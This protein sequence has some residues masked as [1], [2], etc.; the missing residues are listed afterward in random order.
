[1]HRSSKNP[2]RAIALVIVLAFLVLISVMV[3]A[4]LSSVSTEL[5]SSK[6]FASGTNARQLA[7]SAVQAVMGQIR[8]ATTKGTKQAWASQPGMIR[9]YDDS[10]E[11]VSYF[12]LY[13]SD[14]MIVT[15]SQI[16]SFTPGSDVDPAWNAKPALFADLNTPVLV[17]DPATP[18]VSYPVFPIVDPRA[19]GRGSNSPV[20]GFS[21]SKRV[22]AADV[23]GVVVPTS[24]SDNAARLP[25]PVRWL[26]VL[27]DGTLT[28]P[29]DFDTSKQTATWTGA[30]DYKKPSVT[31]PIVGRVA[32]WAD[33]E[34]C[35]ITVGHA[36][37]HHHSGSELRLIPAGAKRIPALSG[38]PLHHG[39]EPGVFSQYRPQHL[40]AAGH[41]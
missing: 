20:E 17:S 6:S 15:K 28:A 32:F 4:F 23:A 35:K 10:G 36:A 37:Q 1:M 8:D 29:T 19:A 7:D 34:T 12:K 21:Y 5:T 25:M 18:N 40:A 24:S 33:D 31:N 16:Q 2:R 41:L 22:G 14:N 27:K 13:S 38:T 11:P 3:V 30:P 9:T 26:Y 39:P